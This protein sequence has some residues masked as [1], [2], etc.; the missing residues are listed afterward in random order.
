M[1]VKNVVL[2][3]HKKGNC[4]RLQL[5]YVIPVFLRVAFCK[6]MA[7]DLRR[8]LL[9]K[10]W[11]WCKTKLS[12][13]VARGELQIALTLMLSQVNPKEKSHFTCSACYSDTHLLCS[14]LQTSWVCYHL[15]A[16]QLCAYGVLQQT[17]RWLDTFSGI[18]IPWHWSNCSFPAKRSSMASQNLQGFW[19]HDKNWD[20]K[21]K[22]IDDLSCVISF[23]LSSLGFYHVVSKSRASSCFN[24]Y[25]YYFK[26]F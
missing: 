25:L 26:W 22:E 15:G 19:Q 17:S 14:W 2:L 13:A 11:R 5:W 1:A 12:I 8:Q 4:L 16:L 3:G 18:E 7:M 21:W 23:L 24:D 6:S 10:H 9:K 20:G